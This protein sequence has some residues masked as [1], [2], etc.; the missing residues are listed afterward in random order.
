M[1]RKYRLKKSPCG[2]FLFYLFDE[3]GETRFLAS[4][5]VFLYE[6]GLC[7]FVYFFVCERKKFHR[8]FCVFGYGKFLDFLYDS[9]K[10]IAM[11]NVKYALSFARAEGFLG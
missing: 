11:T 2:D 5:V 10:R 8:F 1:Y 9:G 6:T 4:G 3:S 7:R